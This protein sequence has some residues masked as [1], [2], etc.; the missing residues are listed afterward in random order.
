MRPLPESLYITECCGLF[1]GG[2][3][4]F[5][6]GWRE[7]SK[8]VCFFLM[9]RFSSFLPFCNFL[10]FFI[11]FYL[12]HSYR[13]WLLR[14]VMFHAFEQFEFNC[15][16]QSLL[17]RRCYTYLKTPCNW[18]LECLEWH[19][20]IGKLVSDSTPVP[21]PIRIRMLGRGSS[22]EQ[23]NLDSECI[24]PWWLGVVK[25]VSIFP[26]LQLSCFGTITST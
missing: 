7:W 13:G 1:E 16:F 6:S 25:T 5:W 26:S 17:S 14:L 9:H 22:W 8:V 3:H 2:Q 20:N 18:K 15:K 19:S 4:F 12:C 10:S 11:L 24:H 21:I 23:W